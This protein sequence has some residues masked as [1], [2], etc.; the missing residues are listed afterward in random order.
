[1]PDSIPRYAGLGRVREPGLSVAEAV[2]RLRR[3]AYTERRMMRLL[4][5][6]IVTIPQRDVKA[7]LA[8]VQH[9]DAQHADALR[10]RVLELRT[11]RSKLEGAPDP[12]LERFFNEAE[13]LPG[14][15]PFLAAVVRVLK[16]AL[17]AAYAAYADA[18][19]ELADYNSVRTVR[20]VAADE[21]EH[22]RLLGAA[23]AALMPSDQDREAAGAWEETL[24]GYLAAAGGVG[25]EMPRG[26]LPASAASREPYRIP[27]AL[28]R[29]G[30]LA[31]VWDYVAPPLERVPERLDYMMGLRLSEINVAEGLAIVLFE[32]EGMPWSFS[33]DISRHLWDEMRHSLY[34]EAAI[35]ETYGDRAAVPMRDY[36]AEFALEAP[37]LEQYAV[38][39]LEVEGKN[40]RYPPGK[41]Q[42]WEF[43]RDMARHPLM[44]TFQDF[45]WADEVL[46]VNIARRQLD[47]WFEGG[48]KAIAE[49]SKRGSAHRT[50]VKHRH[51][52][53][54][55][56]HPTATS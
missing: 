35:E 20:Q 3:L 34:G 21:M 25:G 2:E 52:P 48:L 28:T 27:H 12:A 39:G 32:T 45:D 37:P 30:S 16:P 5:S 41:R 4:A 40:M 43:A 38:L 47:A 18:T 22:D 54:A 9:E 49:F 13:H 10:S 36:E 51:S 23:L 42:E 46:H 14:A 26:P 56:E 31:R 7:L 24:R 53:T 44:T 15:Y 29:D 55:I 17:R 6:R 11:N 1:M 33:L 8:R 19:N 50:E